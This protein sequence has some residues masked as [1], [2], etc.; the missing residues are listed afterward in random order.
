MKPHNSNHIT[1]KLLRHQPRHIL[2]QCHPIIF[3]Q[4]L[5]LKF[6]MKYNLNY[7]HAFKK[8]LG[9]AIC[10]LVLQENWQLGSICAR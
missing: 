3:I 6:H 7:L 2:P 8:V 4:K 5:K 9:T 10:A 1:V